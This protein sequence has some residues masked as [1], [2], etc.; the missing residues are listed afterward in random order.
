MPQPSSSRSQAKPPPSL[1]GL[2]GSPAEQAIHAVLESRFGRGYL[3][4]CRPMVCL[5][6][7]R[8]PSAW[9]SLHPYGTDISAWLDIPPL[10]LALRA[11][12]R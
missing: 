4:S 5:L 11:S 6:L 10:L 2:T 7:G 3:R 1:A 8:P 12:I 9:R